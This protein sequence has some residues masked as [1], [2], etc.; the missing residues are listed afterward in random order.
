[1]H[2]FRLSIV[3]VATM[4]ALSALSSA[5][6]AK[7]GYTSACSSC[8]GGVDVPVSATLVSNSGSA[9]T[10]TFNSP[11]ADAVAV[12]AGSTKQTVLTGTS[13]QFTV[14]NGQTYT[15]YAV[16][17]PSTNS[18]LGRTTVSPVSPLPTPPS[19]APTDDRFTYIAGATRYDTAIQASRQAFPTGAPA[20][21]IATGLNWPDALGGGALAAAV[22]GP[23]LLTD[24]A[25]LP[26]SVAAEIRRLGAGKAYVLGG[27]AAVSTS[28]EQSLRGLLGTSNVTRIA[29]S[30]RYQ[31]AEAIALAVA[32][33]TA[34]SPAFAGG[35]FVTTGA[36]FPDA[37]AATPLSTA[38]RRPIFLVGPQGIAPSTWD[39]MRR[40]GVDEVIVLGGTG[41]V[42]SAVENALTKS[43]G[44]S[45][46]HRLA[47][48]NRYATAVDVATYGVDRF[49]L[50]WDGLAIATGASFP[51]A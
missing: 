10:F 42:S 6:Y 27:T 44:T 34:G 43:F 13:G 16:S 9:S 39:A 40:C 19:P 49:G 30:S 24:P 12:Y 21:V 38:T 18:G 3:L 45:N 1:M 20:V 41:A 8:H 5:A 36:N 7:P 15:I 37:L 50:S 32:A 46:V 23:V 51:D 4:L 29:G 2:R 28:V 48:A 14:A 33:R 22:G 11:A 17:G 35:A 47:G 26:L 31:T 25:S